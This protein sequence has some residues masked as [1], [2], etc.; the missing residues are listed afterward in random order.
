MVT[1][2]TVKDAVN[3]VCLICIPCLNCIPLF[4]LPEAVLMIEIRTSHKK[5]T[6]I[7]HTLSTNEDVKNIT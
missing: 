6:T 3:V 5:Q 1:R 4:H 7:L 2:P